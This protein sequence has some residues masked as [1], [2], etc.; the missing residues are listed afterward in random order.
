MAIFSKT[1][2]A[3]S[4]PPVIG[5]AGMGS[6]AGGNAGA[7]MIGQYY[8]Y[9]EGPARNAAQSVPAISRSRD[10]LASTIGCMKLQQYS[11]MWNGTEMEKI[12]QPPRSWLRQLDPNVSNNFLFSWLVDDLFYFGR[13]MLHV[14]SRYPDGFPRTFTR[15]PIAMV[16]TLDQQGP[17]FFAPSNKVMFQGAQLRTED[18]VQILGGIQGI[19][20]S[21]EQS[22][23]T[24]RKLEAARHR[25]ASSAIPAGVL[26]VQAGS[27]P[28]SSSEL[29]TLA[30][31]F[32][33]AR[34]TNQTAALSPEVHYIETQTS[35]DKMLLI[36]ASEFQV[37]EMANL[38]GVPPYLLGANVGSY[39]YTNAA[40]ARNL[41]WT[42]GARPFADAI[43]SALSMCLPAGQYVEFDVDDYL[44]G[45][46]TADADAKNEMMSN[47]T[48]M[49]TPG[50]I[51]PQ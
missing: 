17:V 49:P 2:A 18:C 4:P 20:Y 25:N 30:A 14:E 34:A 9:F 37:K 46:Y 10:L 1:K 45:D 5:A 26:Q 28:L 3:I 33:A 36:D 40:E 12:A 13:C 48:P 38:C 41:L 42:F 44:E 43:A 51:S 7:N 19:V 21:S 15:I 27:E 23:G 39:S 47:P 24:T 8:S 29:Q 50:V 32:N 6:F 16:T 11:E 22:I 35:P 31:S